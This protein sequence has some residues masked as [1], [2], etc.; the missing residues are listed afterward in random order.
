MEMTQPKRKEGIKELIYLSLSI[1]LKLKLLKYVFHNKNQAENQKKNI[2]KIQQRTI[3]KKIQTQ[4]N[5]KTNNNR[6]RK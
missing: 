6:T 3:T 2:K 4:T 5:T 1:Y